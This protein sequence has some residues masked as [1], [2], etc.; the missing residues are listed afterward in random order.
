MVSYVLCFL[1]NLK[2]TRQI[3][4][5]GY[6]KEVCSRQT[7][8]TTGGFKYFVK[9]SPEILEVVSQPI[10]LTY[11]RIIDNERASSTIENENGDEKI[12]LII[13]IL[14]F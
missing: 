5:C 11:R 13:I 9:R 12:G 2:F 4:T 3:E 7:P 6:I 10:S 1:P 8:E 14:K